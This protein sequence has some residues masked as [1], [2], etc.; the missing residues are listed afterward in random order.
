M[1]HL[2][3]I[4]ILVVSTILICCVVYPLVLLVVGTVFFRSSAEGSLVRD[5]EGSVIGSRL[6][7]QQFK[8][9]KYFWPRPSAAD[10]KGDNSSGSNFGASNPALRERV[11]KQ[12]ETL[13]RKG[14]NVPAD[15]VTA[16]GSGLD[17]HITLRNALSP[18]QLDRVAE[19]R[20]VARGEIEELVRKLAFSPLASEPLV[21]VLELN[22]ELDRQFPM[23]R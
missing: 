19:K 18:A 3:A 14:K 9:E 22:L 10:Y 15:M 11:E 12:L 13:P 4:A 7:A 23:K 21:N 17:P 16:S 8:D 1:K 2:R 20:R 5:E 6:I